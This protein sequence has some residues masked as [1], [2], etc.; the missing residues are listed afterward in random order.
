MTD[1]A[2]VNGLFTDMAARPGTNAFRR[3]GLDV[4]RYASDLGRIALM[5]KAM[6]TLKNDYGCDEIYLEVRVSNYPAINL[7]RSLGMKAVETINHY[8]HEDAY[9]M[10][11]EL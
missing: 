10:A 2:V 8:Y 6:R 11:A 5:L 9:V 1:V 4:A 7:S 3:Y